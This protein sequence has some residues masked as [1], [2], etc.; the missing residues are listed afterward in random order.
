MSCIKYYYF[1]SNAAFIPDYKQDLSFLFAMHFC[2]KITY[3]STIKILFIPTIED[4]CS[5]GVYQFFK[6]VEIVVYDKVPSP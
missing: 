2:N 1:V 5:A 3:N 4:C 6:D